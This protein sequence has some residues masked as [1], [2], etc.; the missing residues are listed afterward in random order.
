[1]EK[2]IYTKLFTQPQ[3]VMYRCHSC[4]I[5]VFSVGKSEGV[6]YDFEV[7]CKKCVPL[8]SFYE[9]VNGFVQGDMFNV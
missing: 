8:E 2:S 3:D 4:G 5:P 6:T 9:T 1:M 7:Y